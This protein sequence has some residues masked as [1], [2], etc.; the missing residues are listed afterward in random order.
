MS[1]ETA[2]TFDKLIRYLK[3]V[4]YEL[5]GKDL[6]FIGFKIVAILILIILIAPI[7]FLLIVLLIS[8]IILSIFVLSYTIYDIE[9]SAPTNNESKVINFNKHKL[10]KKWFSKEKM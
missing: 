3:D 1:E 4:R 6:L 5:S 7:Q 10:N 8:F 9:N 2:Y